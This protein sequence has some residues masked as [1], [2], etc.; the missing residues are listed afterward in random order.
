MPFLSQIKN[1]NLLIVLG[2]LLEFDASSIF[3]SK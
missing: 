3:F 2:L 1:Q